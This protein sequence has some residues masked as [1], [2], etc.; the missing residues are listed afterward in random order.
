MSDFF[1]VDREML[2]GIDLHAL[3]IP[4]TVAWWSLDPGF[5]TMWPANHYPNALFRFMQRHILGIYILNFL[6]GKST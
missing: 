3:S 2:A 4:V 6:K 5:A 1:S